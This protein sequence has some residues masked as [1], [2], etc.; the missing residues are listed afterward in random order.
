M[1][2]ICNPISPFYSLDIGKF[3]LSQKRPFGGY[4]WM[5]H[6]LVKANCVGVKM[7]HFFVNNAMTFTFLYILELPTSAG[8]FSLC[9]HLELCKVSF[10]KPIKQWLHKLEL[11]TTR[12]LVV[13]NQTF[14]TISICFTPWQHYLLDSVI[15]R[16]QWESIRELSSM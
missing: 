3:C 5:I 9:H 8:P 1:W 12:I 11:P 4:S 14:T 16:V 15:L 7:L 2:L 6:S 10:H 13:L